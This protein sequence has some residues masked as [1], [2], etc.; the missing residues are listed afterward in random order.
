MAEVHLVVGVTLIAANLVAGIWGGVSWLERRPTVGFWYALRIAQA[1]VIVQALLG[2]ALAFGGHHA[3]KLHYL[4][5]GLPLVISLLAELIRAGSAAQEL[6]DIDIRSLSEERQT[7]VALAIVRR[8]TGIMATACL[9]IFLL[10]LR[11]AG[12][13]S[14]F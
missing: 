1:T 3:D 10:A 2:L 8:D 7:Q 6:G 13:S 14:A 12:T 9:V 4:Y 11:A 5:G